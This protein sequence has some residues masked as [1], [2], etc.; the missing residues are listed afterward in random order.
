MGLIQGIMAFQFS[1]GP[2]HPYICQLEF[3]HPNVACSFP[4]ALKHNSPKNQIMTKQIKSL[5]FVMLFFSIAQVQAQDP[6]NLALLESTT[7]EERA[8]V[9]TELMQEKLDLNDTTLASLNEIN[10]KYAKKM[11][12]VIKGDNSKWTK[13]RTA[14]RYDKEKDQELQELFSKDQFKAYLKYKD[15]LKV[16]GK[17]KLQE[18]RE[19]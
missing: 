14:K 5:F 10:L 4:I 6:A 13:F 16:D 2:I 17:E 15:Q 8:Q 12:T 9:Q 3:I 18:L 11:E 19:K 1:L 7:P